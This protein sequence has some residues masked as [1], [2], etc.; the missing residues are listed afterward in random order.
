MER[1][2]EPFYA[3]ILPDD[4]QYRALVKKINKIKSDSVV[5]EWGDPVDH[6]IRFSHKIVS[7]N[8]C[9]IR[10]SGDIVVSP[11]IP[12]VVGNIKRHSLIEYWNLGLNKIWEKKI[13]RALTSHIWSIMDMQ[14]AGDNLPRFFK[15]QDIRLDLIDNDLDNIDL[16]R[17]YIVA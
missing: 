3:S 17:R 1:A 4:L 8:K 9:S 5:V 14:F 15:E 11:Y 6:L 10:A 12:L 2:E 7:V 16:I 13:I